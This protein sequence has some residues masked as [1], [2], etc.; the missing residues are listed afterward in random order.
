M[1]GNDLP[2]AV[3][4]TDLVDRNRSKRVSLANVFMELGPLENT[5]GYRIRGTKPDVQSLR[6]LWLVSHDD[7]FTFYLFPQRVGAKGVE[8]VHAG[9][10]EFRLDEQARTFWRR[11]PGQACWVK[12]EWGNLRDRAFWIALAI[13]RGLSRALKADAF[14]LSQTRQDDGTYSITVPVRKA[15]AQL[16][17]AIEPNTDREWYLMRSLLGE[18]PFFPVTGSPS[19]ARFHLNP[20]FLGHNWTRAPSGT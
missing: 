10:F 9:P 18:E 14:A 11:D 20:L 7:H 4:A 8:L 19:S 12:S 17:K 1:L 5:D 13:L 6:A 15:I 2:S 3:E 16:R